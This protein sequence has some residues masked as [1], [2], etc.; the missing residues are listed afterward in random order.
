M[1]FNSGPPMISGAYNNNV[2]I[3][4]S[5]GYVTIVN[6]MIHNTRIIPDRRPPARQDPPVGR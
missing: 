3:L 2:Q 6:E 1:G 5:P 4:Q